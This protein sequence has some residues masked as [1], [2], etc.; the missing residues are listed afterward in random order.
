M[1]ETLAGG[2][3]AA[4][5]NKRKYGDNFYRVIGALGGKKGRT[6]GFFANRE[7]ARIAGA[8]GGTISRRT[9]KEV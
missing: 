2:K 9:K 1:S 7:L 3:A 4:A 8:K 6:G 5:T